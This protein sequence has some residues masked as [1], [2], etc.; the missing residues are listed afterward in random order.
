MT[1][2]PMLTATP[3]PWM[4]QK[5]QNEDGRIVVFD[6]KS[7]NG[8]VLAEIDPEHTRADLDE[9]AEANA[10]LMAAAPKMLKALLAVQDDYRELLRNGPT[11]AEADD[12][13]KMLQIVDAAIAQ[14]TEVRPDLGEDDESECP[15]C[16]DADNLY[17]RHDR[18]ECD[19]CGW[20]S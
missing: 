3:G 4:W 11:D 18:Q 5:R 12:I 14:A 1:D 19:R 10:S 6:P 9:S 2:T 13:D 17:D 20:H 7:D 16:G 8:D 15:N